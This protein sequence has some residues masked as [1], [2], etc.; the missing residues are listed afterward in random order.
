MR[1]LN[2]GERDRGAVLVMTLV[3]T[4]I[5]GV[6]ACALV[7]YAATGLRTSKVTDARTER[8]GLA[9]AGLRIGVE[10]LKKNP[11]ACTRDVTIDGEV[12]RVACA[13][14]VDPTRIGPFRITAAVQGTALTATADVQA[15]TAS[16]KVCG[17]TTEK[18]TV[19]VN[20][21]SVG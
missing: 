20:A 14:V 13:P 12:V 3:L 19:M 1:G 2:H 18:C 4:V 17:T 21:W 9:D 8:V 10:L 5:L 16:G 11:A 7:T 6:V 15:Y